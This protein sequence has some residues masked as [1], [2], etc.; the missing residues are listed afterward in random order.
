MPAEGW[1]DHHAP[2]VWARPGDMRE[3][4]LRGDF[5]AALCDL[6]H[7]P[8]HRESSTGVGAGQMTACRS[9][10]RPRDRWADGARAGRAGLTS[11]H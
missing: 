8:V 2:G 6:L 1:F 7:F 5:G 10:G 11:K 4:L 3:K 9:L